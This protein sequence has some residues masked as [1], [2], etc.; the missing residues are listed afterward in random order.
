MKQN[1]ALCSIIASLVLLTTGC[2]PKADLES[3]Q[4]EGAQLQARVA[5]LEGQVTD[6]EALLAQRELDLQS[7]QH[8]LDEAATQ[9]HESEGA[10][11]EAHNEAVRLA[12]ELRRYVCDQQID[13][14][15]YEDILDIS[16]I[17]SGWWATQPGVERV[18]G[19]Y[20][21]TIWSNAMTKIH[22][23]RFVSSEDHQPYVEHFLVY[24]DELA[25]EHGVFWIGHQ[26]WL[27][28]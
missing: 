13:D 12:A 2:V 20:R 10:Y 24:F 26:C 16:T 19:S 18:Q 1:V 15:E 23:I 11:S 5:E 21:D 22:A 9:L 7:L 17:L 8:D 28:R 4:A 27:D 14:M 3:A 6:Q 25:M